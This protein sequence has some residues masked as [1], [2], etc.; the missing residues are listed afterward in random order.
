MTFLKTFFFML[1]V[2]VMGFFAA[3][4]I[5]ATQLEIARRS[6]HGYL[7]SALMI[8]VGSVLSDILYG[9]VA[10]FGIASFLQNPKV[11]AIFWLGGG[12]LLVVLGVWVIRD[13]LRPRVV[14]ME[15]RKMLQKQD[16]AFITGFSLAVTNPLMVVWWLLGARLLKDIGIM[17]RYGTS[18]TLL[19]LPACLRRLQGEEVCLTAN[20]STHHDCLWSGAP[21]FGNLFHRAI[22]FG[23]VPSS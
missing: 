7:S 5:G 18:E 8:M 17:E 9:V 10:F 23:V 19:F 3:I 6:L 2:Y 20:D 13:G 4:P 16:V 22:C 11:V 14:D 21:G 15:S 12:G 1:C